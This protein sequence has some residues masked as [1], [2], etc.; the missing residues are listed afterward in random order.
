ML[1][2]LIKS[3]Y[4]QNNRTVEHQALVEMSQTPFMPYIYRLYAQNE[5]A[6]LVAYVCR[7]CSFS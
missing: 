6:M 2:G 1:V 3:K 5:A 7:L 4:H